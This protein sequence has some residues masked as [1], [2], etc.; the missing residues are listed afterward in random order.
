MGPVNHSHEFDLPKKVKALGL[1]HAL[2]AKAKDGSI[3]ILDE[4]KSKEIKTGTLAKQFGMDNP[5]EIP[6][7]E[8][9]VI[10][11]GMG[12][13]IKNPKVLDTVVNELGIITGQRPVIGVNNSF[14]QAHRV[15]QAT[16]RAAPPLGRPTK[17]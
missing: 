16:P 14:E 3:V 7:L 2:S 11:C 17:K 5:H 12:E 13:A 8:K 15:D 9:I 1:R 6:T 4:A 10:N